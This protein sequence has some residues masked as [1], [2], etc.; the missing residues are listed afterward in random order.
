MAST[1]P[2]ERLDKFF[3]GFKPEYVLGTTYTLSLAFFESVIF[4]AIPKERLRK[5]VILCDATGYQRAMAEA[6][7]LRNATRD[8]LVAIAPCQASFH[9]KVWTL[10]N[11]SQLAVLVGSGNL[12]QSGFIENLEL[13]EVLT[14][15]RGGSGRRSAEGVLRF[16]EGLVQILPKSPGAT[17]IS[18]ESLCE[19]STA[20]ESIC[21]TLKVESDDNA[22]FWSSFD[23]ESVEEKLRTFG[24]CRRVLVAA[25]YFGRSLE[26]VK[27]VSNACSP[28]ELH[29][30]PAIHD[31][32]CIDL[33]VGDLRKITSIPPKILK[34]AEGGERFTHLKIYGLETESKSSWLFATSANCTRAALTG[35]NV[36]AGVWRR[37]TSEV[38]D[39]YFASGSVAPDAMTVDEQGNRLRNWIPLWATD[40]GDR[41]NLIASPTSSHR[42]PLRSV[43]VTL[44]VGSA[45]YSTSFEAMFESAITLTI[46]WR[47]FG[48][49]QRHPAARVVQL[50]GMDCNGEEVSGT[51]LVDDLIALTAEPTHRGAWRAAVAMLA[52][53]G[54]PAFA[55]IS[56]LLQLADEITT[57]YADESEQSSAIGLPSGST[58]AVRKDKI[59]VWPPQPIV[60]DFATYRSAGAGQVY[61]FDR[62]LASLASPPRVAAESEESTIEQETENDHSD[63]PDDA[64]SKQRLTA[65][66]RLWQRAWQSQE[67]LRNRLHSLEISPTQAPRIWGPA[68]V[69]ML[70]VMAVRRAVF[71]ATESRINV[72]R[73]SS[74]ASRFLCLIFLDRTQ[75]EDFEA[76]LTSPY[77]GMRS[78]PPIAV[79]LARRFDIHPQFLLCPI[80]CVAFAHVRAVGLGQ[81]SERSISVGWARFRTVAG[82]FCDEALRD[83]AHLQNV[84]ERYFL[85]TRD[86]VTWVSVRESLHVLRSLS[87]R[88]LESA[89][90][91][92]AL[93]KC[94]KGSRERPA[95][96][97][98]RLLAKL[99]KWTQSHFRIRAI[100]RADSSCT[101]SSCARAGFEDPEITRA[102]SDLR[103]VICNA[104][105]ALLVP[106][107]LYDALRQ[108]HND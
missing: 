29:I 66:D 37:V 107:E 46:P 9:A 101:N 48:E 104:C 20:I 49:L 74:L 102:A 58:H 6:T 51:V 50:N 56:A 73:S 99:D 45:R 34:Y 69:V 65:C 19:I 47:A 43:S 57:N 76:T 53:D 87:W 38:L 21:R 15:E 79:D 17:L 1:I 31:G 77:A 64:A 88:E 24:K 94:A 28:G 67:A 25:P 30:F 23:A 71:Q 85:D 98:A 68:V 90:D 105:G 5:C 40:V 39:S 86:A 44:L 96:S 12:T 72:P 7:A 42:F 35:K 10:I 89:R 97:D 4:P 18:V 14:F 70:T 92:I 16:V 75:A 26:G 91:L 54:L 33:P 27:I 13:F 36:E 84:W 2:R 78:F 106:L 61:W 63:L 81:K 3:R 95:L 59:A 103:P 100:D 82:D 22:R 11:D 93:Q 83:E 52:S 8:Y 108:H 60:L 41:L 32:D 55:D 62:V 80:L